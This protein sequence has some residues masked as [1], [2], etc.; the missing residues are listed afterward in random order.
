VVSLEDCTEYAESQWQK[1]LLALVEGRHTPLRPHKDLPGL[2]IQ[3]LFVGAGLLDEAGELTQAGFKF[4]FT[5][6][7]SQLWLLLQHYLTLSSKEEGTQL[8]SALSF[9]LQLS[10]RQVRC[11]SQF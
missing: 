10:F 1:V 6:L 2:G 11:P 4:L 9:L 7:Y 5:D 3:K 8:A